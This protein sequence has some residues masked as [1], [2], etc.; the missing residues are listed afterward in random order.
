MNL[1]AYTKKLYEKVNFYDKIIKSKNFNE[2]SINP[3]A[4][5]ITLTVIWIEDD[6]D[7]K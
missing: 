2:Y 1:L 3:F 6:N 5:P 7:F 4:K